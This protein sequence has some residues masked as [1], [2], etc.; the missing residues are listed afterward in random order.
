M[1]VRSRR[2]S[3]VPQ[4]HNA[5]FRWTF[6]QRKHAIGLLRA[7]LPPLVAAEVDFRALKVEKDSFVDAALRSR[8]GDL[9]LSTKLRGRHFYFYALFEHQRGVEPL[10]IFRMSV[11]MHRLWEKLVR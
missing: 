2:R 9:V 7:A 1:P 10:M 11:Y 8:Y 3:L 6:G 5:I 4:P